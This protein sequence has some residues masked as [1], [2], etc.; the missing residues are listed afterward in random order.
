[1]QTGL[2]CVSGEPRHLVNF[3]ACCPVLQLAVPVHPG[4]PNAIEFWKRGSPSSLDLPRRLVIHAI[5]TGLVFLAAMRHRIGPLMFECFD[6]V[7]SARVE[8]SS[9]DHIVASQA[10]EKLPRTLHGIDAVLIALESY[11]FA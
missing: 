7:V 11:G 6:V 1:M 10:L 2:S 3:T 9:G 5:I 4:T 8:C